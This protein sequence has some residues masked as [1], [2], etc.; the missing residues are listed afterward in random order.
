MQQAVRRARGACSCLSTRS[1]RRFR[2]V[3]LWIDTHCS[4]RCCLFF[5]LFLTCLALNLFSRICVTCDLS[6]VGSHGQKE[7]TMHTRM[8]AHSRVCTHACMHTETPMD[9]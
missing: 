3:V 5:S 9:T 2:Q 6:P 8:Y 1:F 4:L 7:H